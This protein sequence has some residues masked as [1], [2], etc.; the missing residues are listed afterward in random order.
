MRWRPSSGMWYVLL[1]HTGYSSTTFF[2]RQWGA[3]ALGDQPMAGDYDGDGVTDIAVW[4]SSSGAWYLL[5]SSMG[6]SA[7]N[8]R[9]VQWGLGSAGD[10]PITGDYDGDG[11]SDLVVWRAPQGMW[12]ILRSSTNF[13]Q[14]TSV[15]WGGQQYGDRPVPR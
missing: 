12:Y 7:S 11:K 13:S 8:G 15:Q 1:S 6:L 9:S 2:S 14:Y 10:I 5:L 4:R 3:T